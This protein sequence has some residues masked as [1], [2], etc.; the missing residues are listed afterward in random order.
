MVIDGVDSYIVKE[1][2]YSTLPSVYVAVAGV[3]PV[4]DGK[5]IVDVSPSLLVLI[6]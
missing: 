2:L 4:T 1:E 3:S 5:T 6:V